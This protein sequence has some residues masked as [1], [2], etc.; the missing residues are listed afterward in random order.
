MRKINLL[1][2]WPPLG[3]HRGSRAQ[4]CTKKNEVSLEQFASPVAGQRFSGRQA[5]IFS[6][7]PRDFYA[8]P[9]LESGSSR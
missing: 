8:N 1:Q 6:F 7:P 9:A 2:D 5:G 3:A 4:K